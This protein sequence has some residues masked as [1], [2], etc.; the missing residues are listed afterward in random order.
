LTALRWLR[1]RWW[2]L[3]LLTTALLHGSCYDTP[4]IADDAASGGDD[5][6]GEVSVAG[7]PSA[8]G[9]GGSGGKPSTSNSQAGLPTTPDGGGAATSLGGEPAGAGQGG[10][11]P[12][13]R[14]RWLSLEA[15]EAPATLTPNQELGVQ[16]AFYAYSDSCADVT[17]DP[18]T[19]CVSGQMCDPSLQP[20]AWGVAI[21][22]DF[23]NTGASGS[24]PNTK[25]LWNPEDVGAV[26]VAW[27]VTGVAPGLQVWVLNMAASWQ[28][29]CA[30]MSCEIDGPPDG[31]EAASLDGELFFNQM[32][33]DYWGGAGVRYDFNPA[34]VHALQFK[35]PAIRVHAASF[36]FCVDAL[37]VIR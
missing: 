11:S 17:W 26:G 3:A 7:S 33:K 31:V 25:L 37:G 13:P 19:R 22:F 35:L 4:L 32:T 12:V 10:E 9:H 24:P 1:S 2:L 8:T 14:V 30:A 6:A 15:S 28:G 29:Q 36:D 5:A 23:R 16:G 18:R 27:Q 21:G 20:D 34:A